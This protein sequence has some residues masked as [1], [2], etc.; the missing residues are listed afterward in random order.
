MQLAPHAQTIPLNKFRLSPHNVRKTG[1]EDNLDELGA[2]IV[3]HG[4]LQ[5]LIGGAAKK[6]GFFDI[7][8]GGRR[9][10]ALNRL[11]ASGKIAADYGV[12]VRVALSDHDVAEISLAE[13]F[14]R[15]GMTPT[16]E[17][18]AFLHFLAWAKLTVPG[19][20]VTMAR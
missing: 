19:L 16:D 6:R 10:R 5:N 13:N 1:A 12:P 9:L 17:C 14:V 15:L 8:A 2:N 4:V 20:T 3:A 7:F 18:Q 11:A